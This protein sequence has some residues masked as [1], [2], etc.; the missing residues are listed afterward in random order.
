MRYSILRALSILLISTMPCAVQGTDPLGPSDEQKNRLLS[1]V[2]SSDSKDEKPQR[3]LSSG[4]FRKH[5]E[6]S[7]EEQLK[8]LAP[9]KDRAPNAYNNLVQNIKDQ[10]QNI[11]TRLSWSEEDLNNAN[12]T[13]KSHI[14]L[15]KKDYVANVKNFLQ[16]EID[17][18]SRAVPLFEKEGVRQGPVLL[19]KVA[20]LMDGL[21]TAEGVAE[22]E[23]KV[24]QAITEHLTEALKF[25]AGFKT[26]AIKDNKIRELVEAVIESAGSVDQKYNIRRMTKQEYDRALKQIEILK[27]LG[28][29]RSVSADILP[30]Y[31]ENAVRRLNTWKLD[32]DVTALKKNMEQ[33]LRD[34]HWSQ[35]GHISNKKIKQVAE[36]VDSLVE[37]ELRRLSP[38]RFWLGRL[39][40]PTT[41]A[42]VGLAKPV[43][44]Y[45]EPYVREAIQDKIL[46]PA[47]GT[48]GVAAYP[49]LQYVGEAL[50][51]LGMQWAVSYDLTRIVNKA[52]TGQ[53]SVS[54]PD[55]TITLPMMFMV[56]TGYQFMG[57]LFL[58]LAEFGVNNT[59]GDLALKTA[60]VTSLRSWSGFFDQSVPVALM[61]GL[62]LDATIWV[63]RP[64]IKRLRA[65]PEKPV[66][67]EEEAPVASQN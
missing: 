58:S 62:A 16:E 52:T 14:N 1:N 31:L 55:S 27:N 33:A 65:Q 24:L 40:I 49:M 54:G 32:V 64:L 11:G 21:K 57:N 51:T 25:S 30:A 56:A 66:A 34:N 5:F 39:A 59:V 8:N 42:L 37:Q 41:T 45:A 22:T 19:A 53:P 12:R 26:D 44:Q 18:A 43:L 20:P 61:T 13:L 28:D 63:T 9:Y 38:L 4:E 29:E 46:Y 50:L 17:L 3:A 15:F 7:V 67:K 6:K 23:Q 47:F 60:R 2:P 35:S 48:M 36:F 10:K